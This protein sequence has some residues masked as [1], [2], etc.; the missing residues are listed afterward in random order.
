MIGSLYLSALI[1]VAAI[2]VADAQTVDA[3]VS[4]DSVYTKVDQ[5]P[6][7][8]GGM[9][10]LMKLVDGNHHYP[11]EAR[12]NKI[13]G[14]VFL[15]FVIHEDGTP[16]NFKV[17]QG[18]GYGCDEAALEAFRTMPKWVPGKLAGKPVKVKLRT[19]YLYGM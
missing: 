8:S 2:S 7:F 9:K 3:H 4:T 1:L 16:G 11:K 5:M 6:Q 13:Q 10:A 15:E 14:K 12:K 18:L 17:T 19:A